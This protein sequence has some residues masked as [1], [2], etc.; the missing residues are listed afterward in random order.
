[1]IRALLIS[2]VLLIGGCISLLPKPPPA[3]ALYVLEAGQAQAAQ[4]E[5]LDAVLGVAAPEGERTILGSDLV[6]RT[7]DSIAF[8][9]GAQWTGRAED[10]LR[11]VL[12]TTVNDQRLFRA[13]VPTGSASSNYQLRWTVQDFEVFEDTMSARFSADVMVLAPG[14]RVIASEHISAEAPVSDRAASAASQALTRAAREGS[15]RI[16]MFAAD[17]VAADIVRAMAEDQAR[18]AS[19]SR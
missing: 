6:W 13:A 9:S 2:P 11:N 3:P 16:G 18:A 8:V 10:L 5:R 4:R 19:I 1:M 12:V 7:G 15:A 14:R 17:A